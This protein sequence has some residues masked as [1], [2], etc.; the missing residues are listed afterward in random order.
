MGRDAL[1]RHLGPMT[2]CEILTSILQPFLLVF[3]AIVVA[4]K[5]EANFRA[6]LR[7]FSGSSMAIAAL[8][9][10]VDR[11]VCDRGVADGIAVTL[12][13]ALL[14]FLAALVFAWISDRKWM[15]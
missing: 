11:A 5:T 6:R 7:N 13:L 3:I 12:G 1:G 4:R 8:F 15:R 2:P 10:G 9:Y 14:H